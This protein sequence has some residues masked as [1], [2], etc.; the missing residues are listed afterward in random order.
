[1]ADIEARKTPEALVIAPHPFYPAGVAAGD[2][3]VAH[4]RLFD[5]VEFSG[6]YTALTPRFNRR[7]ADYAQTAGIAVVGNSDTHFLWQLGRT[8]TLIDA[9]PEIGAVVDALRHR[10]VQLVTQP[11]SWVQL[12]RFLLQS[13]STV[14]T[15]TDGMRYMVQVLRRTRGK[16]SQLARG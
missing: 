12:A 4:P 10:R 3:L 8:Y 16:S 15:L 5:A 6:L 9:A 2:A 1:L 11:L 14:S 13:R 7:A